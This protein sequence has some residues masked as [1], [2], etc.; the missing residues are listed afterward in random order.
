MANYVT[1]PVTGILI[2]TPLVDPG[3][4][5][6]FNVSN[7]LSTLAHLTHTGASNLDGYQI[8][9]AGLNINADVSFQSNN[10]TSLRSA[11]FSSQSA[12]LTSSGDI[13][14]VYVENGNLYYNN[15]EGVVIP[16]TE[17]GSVAVTVPGVYQTV[18]ITTNLTIN[19]DGY[20]SFI[21]CN[22]VSPITITLPTSVSVPTGTFYIIKDAIGNS[23]NDK[24]TIRTTGD[25][26]D[27]YSNYILDVNM[28]AVCLVTDGISNWMVLPFDRTAWNSGDTLTMNADS[29]LIMNADSTLDMQPNSILY[30]NGALIDVA[31][32]GT[33]LFA[34]GTSE[35]FENSSNLIL[36][37]GAVQTVQS[38][39]EIVLQSG[40]TF[41]S[42]GT[43]NVGI[44]PSSYCEMSAG[45]TFLLDTGAYF[46]KNGWDHW[47]IAQTRS[48][49]QGV[50]TGAV[51]VANWFVDIN[52]IS[53][54]STGQNVI[55][56]LLRLHQGATLNTV[57]VCWAVDNAHTGGVPTGTN[58]PNL[59]LVRT[60]YNSSAAQ[61]LSSTNIQY[62]PAPSSIGAYV[63][64]NAP[65][66]TLIY[67]CNQ[68]NIIDN[69][70][71]QYALQISDENDQSGN[72]FYS[73]TSAFT[74]I[75]TQQWNI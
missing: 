50:N 43:F 53:A 37:S 68:N 7:A 66:S 41:S 4:D 59:Q 67:T 62:L 32:N 54:N 8:P 56:P 14:C 1:D 10:I 39:G 2:P 34:A 25:T 46:T 22:Q 64:G 17:G 49:V 11:R 44:T 63:N 35:T 16:I 60:L 33:I 3:P 52:F 29:T 36:N 28:A 57:T 75:T 9:S 71:Y 45:A 24:I 12:P 18:K 5:Y 38:G 42:V 74:N 58:L 55:V 6:A 40:S 21:E 65:Q 26:I 20:Y 13:D 48:L 69:T 73:I 30:I 31:N 15:G 27:G 47:A 61:Y 70:Q 19:P 51:N 23:E 72:E